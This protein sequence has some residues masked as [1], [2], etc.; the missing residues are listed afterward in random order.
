MGKLLN[1][2]T[3]LHKASKRDYL[4]R[5]MDDKINCM[6]IAKQFD[7]NFWD[8]ERK[9]GYGGYKY[10][11]RWE[12]VARQLIELYSLKN[13]ARILDVGCGKGYLLYEIKKLLPESEIKGFDISPYA[14]ENSKEEIKKH[15]YVYKAQAPY[16]FCD[17]EFDL[18]LSLTTLH[19]LH[20]YE[21]KTAL[22]EIQRVGKNKYIVM[23]SYR[24]EKELFNL[25]CWALTCQSFFMYQEWIWIFDEFGYTG[26]YEF[27]Y[28]E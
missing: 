11:G 21:L 22:K 9:F 18:V 20:I 12:T 2:I 6:K 25:Q 7:Q 19:N 15:L 4:N 8:G 5:M 27:I 13:N 10:D 14:I 24:N 17:K 26:D 28:F 23:E 16:P 1:I 3:Q